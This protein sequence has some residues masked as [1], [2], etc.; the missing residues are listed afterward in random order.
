[1]GYVS[2]AKLAMLG[3][4][5]LDTGFHRMSCASMRLFCWRISHANMHLLIYVNMELHL[6]LQ[7]IFYVCIW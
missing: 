4:Y 1:M 3:A 5:C 2:R 7:R 6:G